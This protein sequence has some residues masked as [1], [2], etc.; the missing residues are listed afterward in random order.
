MEAPTL[1]AL[2]EL[3]LNSTAD[4]K[5]M[6][7]GCG[8]GLMPAILTLL[9]KKRQRVGDW[10]TVTF[11]LICHADIPA[12]SWFTKLQ[13]MRAPCLLHYP[14]PTNTQGYFIFSFSPPDE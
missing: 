3:I 8:S 10:V 2:R 4:L 14:C 1:T 9:L 11:G 12:I 7:M 5:V 13:P 6:A